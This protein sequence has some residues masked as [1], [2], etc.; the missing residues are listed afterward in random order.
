MY[1]FATVGDFEITAY[2]GAIGAETFFPKSQEDARTIIKRLI[3]GDYAVIFVS[4]RYYENGFE[5]DFLPAVIPIT[6]EKSDFA[7]ERI[8][9]YVKRAIGQDM[10]FDG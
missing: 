8:S 1:K 9:A 3:K 10:N 6:S 4:E 2:F 5:T 7:I